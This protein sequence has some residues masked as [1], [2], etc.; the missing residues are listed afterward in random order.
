M[1][2]PPDRARAFSSADGAYMKTFVPCP[3]PDY[4]KKCP[5]RIATFT[6]RQVDFSPK[7]EMGGKP[8]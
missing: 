2:L 7:I 8:F 1:P 6:K 3:T 4:G 5:K